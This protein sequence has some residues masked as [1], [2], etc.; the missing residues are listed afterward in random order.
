MCVRTVNV[1]EARLRK[2]SASFKDV[3]VI[4]QWLQIVIN[5]AIDD[6][7]LGDLTELPLATVEKYP[8]DKDMTV[9]ELYAAVMEDVKAIYA[10]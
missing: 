3:N 9:E 10:E 6:M 4:D 5:N 7:E 2:I 8:Y 1:D